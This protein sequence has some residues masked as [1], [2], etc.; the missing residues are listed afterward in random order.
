M[1]FHYLSHK[2]WP[3]VIKHFSYSTQL[4]TKF[5]LLINVKMTIVGILTFI[6][7]INTATERLK[8][9]NFYIC[10]Y[11]S[12]YEQL[13]FHAQLSWAWKSFVTSG[14]GLFILQVT[15]E[16]Q[17]SWFTIPAI[18]NSEHETVLTVPGKVSKLHVLSRKGHW[19]F[20]PYTPIF[21]IPRTLL[22]SFWCGTCSISPIGEYNGKR[23]LAKYFKISYALERYGG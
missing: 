14:P 17:Y 20:R 8:T 22:L 18:G 5:I 6:S 13:K 16:K 23:Q 9:R 11:F 12:F 19:R 4:S 7:M 10:R 3:E 21:L 1:P 15:K 2:D